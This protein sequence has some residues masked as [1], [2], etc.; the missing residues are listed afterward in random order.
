ME[1]DGMRTMIVW[2]MRG[3]DFVYNLGWSN[4]PVE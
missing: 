2:A 4:E 1:D 3:L